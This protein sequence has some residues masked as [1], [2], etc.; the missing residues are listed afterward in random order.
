M[1]TLQF[2]RFKVFPAGGAEP[3]LSVQPGAQRSSES[4]YW[5]KNAVL[6]GI[7]LVLYCKAVAIHTFPEGATS[8]PQIDCV[9]FGMA[10][11]DDV[12]HR[13]GRTSEV[14]LDKVGVICLVL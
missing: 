7:R 3:L 8:L 2:A 1:G 10:T 5:C 6:P 13:C 12:N 11:G 4:V 14:F 9:A